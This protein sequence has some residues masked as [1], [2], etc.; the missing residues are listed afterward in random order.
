MLLSLSQSLRQPAVEL[1]VDLRRTSLATAA[2]FRVHPRFNSLRLQCRSD[3][4]D[5]LH[6]PG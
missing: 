1:D 5:A 2:D 4:N 6:R 3:R